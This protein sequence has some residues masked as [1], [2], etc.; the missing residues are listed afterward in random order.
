MTMKLAILGLLMES[1][2]HPYELRQ[3][4]KEREMHH[5]MK[6]QEGSLY[7]AIEQL[8]KDGFVDVVDVVRNGNR[9]DRTIYKITVQGKHEFEKLL[10]ERFEEPM[11]LNRPLYAAVKFSNKIDPETLK[12]KLDER[13]KEIEAFAI[14]MKRV[15]EEHV[16]HV[17]RSS[18]HLMWGMHEQS[19]TELRLLQRLR[20]DAH[21]GRLHEFSGPLTLEVNKDEVVR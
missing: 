6:L 14:R 3:K 21:A 19:V 16:G 5:Y 4:M 17:P 10:L 18:L 20:D 8:N 11:Q 15:Y 13:I 2:S 7:Y 1:D 12:L 9:P